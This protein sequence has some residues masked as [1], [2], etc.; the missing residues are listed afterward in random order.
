MIYSEDA[1]TLENNLHK[2]F[3]SQ[4]V[5][6]MNNRKEFF[7][8]S[9]DEIEIEARRYAPEHEFIRIAEASD[10]RQSLALRNKLSKLEALK[11]VDSFPEEI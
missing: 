9:L 8:V 2:V 5:N 3:E 11:A 10:Y 6:L 1:P 7:S 4:R